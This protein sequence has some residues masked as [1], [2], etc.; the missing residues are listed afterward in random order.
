MGLVAY[1]AAPKPVYVLGMTSNVAD[2][3]GLGNFVRGFLWP[4]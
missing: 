4:E 3:N 1:V 2:R